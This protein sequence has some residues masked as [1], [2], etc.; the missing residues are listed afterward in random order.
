[1]TVKIRVVNHVV[2][3]QKATWRRGGIN[4]SITLVEYFL[5]FSLDTLTAFISYLTKYTLN[6]YIGTKGHKTTWFISRHILFIKFCEAHS[7]MSVMVDRIH[8]EVY[9]WDFI[10]HNYF[11]FRIFRAFYKMP[12]WLKNTLKKVFRKCFSPALV[13]H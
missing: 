5:K 3:W 6:C 7:H 9:R 4:H 11:E 13:W 2:N 12:I 10:D 8:L 1:M